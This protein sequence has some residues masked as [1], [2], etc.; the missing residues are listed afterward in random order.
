MDPA[1]VFSGDADLADNYVDPGFINTLGV[2]GDLIN[3]KLPVSET[4]FEVT[5]TGNYEIPDVEVMTPKS[6]TIKFKLTTIF[7]YLSLKI[8]EPEDSLVNPFVIELNPIDH[9]EENDYDLEVKLD[10][11]D[12][13]L[14]YSGSVN[15]FSD[16]I[17]RDKTLTVANQNDLTSV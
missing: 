7:D 14:V 15:G 8:V 10:D 1:Y 4:A 2:S 6:Q 13:S 16:T 9:I 5:I 3:F 12:V 11:F 17:F